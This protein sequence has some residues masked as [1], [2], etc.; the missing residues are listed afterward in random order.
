MGLF[1]SIR[2]RFHRYFLQKELRQIQR[3]PRGI[4]WDDA[5]AIGILF[6]ATEL[7]VRQV[8]VAYK[9]K[10]MK[11]GKKVQLLGFF[12]DDQNDPN[13]T[14][15]H[16]NRKQFD[17]ALRPTSAEVREFIE[18]PFDLLINLEPVTHSHSE[19]I[20]ACS[21]A[22]LRVG[23]YTANTYCYDLMI[24]PADRNNIQAFIQQIESLLKK[25]NTRH[26]TANA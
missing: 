12:N 2:L 1:T 15:H 18:T 8:V 4:N 20:A 5:H 14:F 19:Y 22:H 23:P 6:D 24:E 3:S 17:W 9:E 13:F 10:L 26:E 11:E 21:R 25:T 7:S 16:F